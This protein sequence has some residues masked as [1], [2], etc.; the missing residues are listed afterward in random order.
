MTPVESYVL[1]QTRLMLSAGR[2]LPHR[3]LGFSC[4]FF[5]DISSLSFVAIG[6]AIERDIAMAACL[7]VCPSHAGGASKPMIVGSCGLHRWEAPGLV[8]FLRPTFLS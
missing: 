1:L 7:S 2:S 6:C 3:R 8:S 4:F 5:A